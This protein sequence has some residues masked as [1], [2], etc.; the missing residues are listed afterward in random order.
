MGKF[1]LSF[2][3]TAA[4]LAS[5]FLAMLP[6]AWM[7]AEALESSYRESAI[8]DMTSNAAVFSLAVGP[9]LGPGGNRDELLKIVRNARIGSQTRYTVISGDGKVLADSDE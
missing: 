1:R 8:R 5:G 9:V 3:L 7:G 2:L 6:M 4:V